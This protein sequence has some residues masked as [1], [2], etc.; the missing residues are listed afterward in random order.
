MFTLSRHL[1]CPSTKSQLSHNSSSILLHPY[2]MKIAAQESCLRQS[3][4]CRRENPNPHL[5]I[6]NIMCEATA[7]TDKPWGFRPSAAAAEIKTQAQKDIFAYQGA[8]KLKGYV[9]AVISNT[10][11]KTNLVSK[12]PKYA[13]NQRQVRVK[14]ASPGL[15]T[16]A[17]DKSWTSHGSLVQ[18]QI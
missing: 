4:F 8:P 5:Y 18:P 9:I 3:C 10:A 13:A 15:P 6:A 11:I 2:V 7:S 16:T 17:S 1:L 14:I 12:S